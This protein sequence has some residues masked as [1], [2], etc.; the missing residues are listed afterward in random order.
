MTT[1]RYEG[2]CAGNPNM[3]VTGAAVCYAPTVE[4]LRRAA[5]ERRNLVISREH[6]FFLHGGVNYSYTTEDLEAALQGDPVV[7]AKRDFIA[8]HK[9]MVYRCGAAWDQFR[10]D[11]Q[12]RALARALGLAPIEWIPT[13]DPFEVPAV[14]V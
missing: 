12:Y 14:R 4:F 9:L 8:A 3:E 5:R 6:P 1:A 11:A 7:E 13:G 2:L 10:P